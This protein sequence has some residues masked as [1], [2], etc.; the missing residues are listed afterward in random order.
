MYSVEYTRQALKDMDRLPAHI[1]GAIRKKLAG[2]AK[3]PLAAAGVKALAGES[4]AY[5]LRVGNYRVVYFLEH[6]RLLIVVVKA[7]H[8]KDVY[9]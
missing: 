4:G 6:D 3:T 7:Q 5:R 1:Q 2:L 8:R 9:R